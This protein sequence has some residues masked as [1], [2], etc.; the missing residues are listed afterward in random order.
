ME[1]ETIS[2]ITGIGSSPTALS[3]ART[4]ENI[5]FYEHWEEDLDLFVR[6]RPRPFEPLSSGHV[7]S[8]KDEGRSIKQVLI[9]TAVSLKRLKKKGFTSWSTSIILI[10]RWLFKSKGMVGKKRNR[11]CLPGI[12][13]FCFKTYGDLVDQWITFNEPIVPVE[14]GYFYDAHFLIR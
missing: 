11:L 3:R 9:S 1:R 12:C 14:F 7:F 4:R 10:Y 5:D 8:Q 6:N 2:G 13:A